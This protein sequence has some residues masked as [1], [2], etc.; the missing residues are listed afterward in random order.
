MARVQKI[1]YKCGGKNFGKSL[2]V[3][4][5]QFH[6]TPHIDVLLHPLNIY[7]MFFQ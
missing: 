2:K 4:I 5:G 7:R 3:E 6:G 1:G